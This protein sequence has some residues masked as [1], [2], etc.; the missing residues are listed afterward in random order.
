MASQLFCCE[1]IFGFRSSFGPREIFPCRHRDF[2]NFL[3]FF[4]QGPRSPPSPLLFLQK[5]SS[6]L[7]YPS[8]EGHLVFSKWHFGC[9]LRGL[10]TPLQ[11]RQNYYPIALPNW[12]SML[13][14][15]EIDS[16]RMSTLHFPAKWLPWSLVILDEFFCKI[17]TYDE[18][19]QGQN[20]PY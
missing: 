14:E 5:I 8:P 15:F 11:S 17:L 1:A 3:F 12:E 7:N 19:L 9:G 10:W 16:G 13:C 20:Y 4:F 2:V 18:K 6:M